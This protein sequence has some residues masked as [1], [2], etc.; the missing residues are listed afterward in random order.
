MKIRAQLVYQL[1]GPLPAAGRLPVGYRLQLITENQTCERCRGPL[2]RVRTFCRI[3]LGILL[4]QPR[5][6]LVQKQCVGCGWK[7]DPLEIYH[8]LVPPQGNY[9]FDLMVEVGLARLRNWR[10][11]AEIRQDVEQ[12]WGLSL[13]L[14]GIGLLV[15]SFLDGLAALHQAHAPALR[16]Q[17]EKDGGYALHLDG[18]CE[19]GT[20]THFVALAAPRKWILQCSKI[21][22][23]N[24][25]EIATVVHRCVENFSTPLAVMRDLSKNIALAKQTVIPDVPDLICQYHFLENVGTKLCETPH[26]KLTACLRRLK[27]RAA[28]KSVRN[29]LVRWNKKGKSP[30]SITQVEQLLSHPDEA[31]EL[32]L[33]TLRRL[34]AYL[35]LRWLDDYCADL[36]SEYF[37]FDLPSLAFYRR[38]RQLADWLKQVTAAENF[39]AQRFPTLSTIVRH[40]APLHEDPE[41][42]RAAAR[43]EK[44]SSLFSKLRRVMRLSHSRYPGLR[45]GRGPAETQKQI[46]EIPARLTAWREGLQQRV[47]LENDPDQRTDQQ[48]VLK[49]LENY[50]QG[51]VGHVI[52]LKGHAKPLVVSRTNN[53]LEQCFG[54]TK[55]GKRRQTGLKN[56]AR[57]IE[58][59]RPEAFLVRN[60]ED[61]TYLDLVCGGSLANLANHLA[62]HWPAAQAIRGE[63]KKTVTEHPMPTTKKQIRQPGLFD[64]V[65]RL[66][67]SIVDNIS[68]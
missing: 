29:D 59:M 2:R 33:V 36:H 11:D 34:V 42:V 58:A 37:P 1:A 55:K 45:R 28:L 38:G 56:L 51:L 22:A 17:L 20:G 30:L 64:S 48:T 25:G 8:R 9:A 52:A 44:A 49:Y 27:V 57:Q 47:L 19:P 18:T 50:H 66:L 65:K 23:E 24:A 21:S 16:Q 63:R 13:P 41:I 5:M 3:P 62:G 26:G 12:R 7:D 60:L 14:S 32:D 40:L 6:Q 46:E 67:A 68:P 4:G 53:V 54:T 31:A 61:Q 43:L 15:D 10:Q 35:L 39:P